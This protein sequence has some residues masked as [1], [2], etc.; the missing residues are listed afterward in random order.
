MNR[1]SPAA[2]QARE[3]AR[4]TD[5]RFG[6][7]EAGESQ[8]ELTGGDR[9][10]TDVEGIGAYIAD[11]AEELAGTTVGDIHSNWKARLN[12]AQQ[13]A[14]EA[15]PAP[16]QPHAEDLTDEHKI[17]IFQRRM[18]HHAGKNP[19]DHGYSYDDAPDQ[20]KAT[21]FLRPASPQWQQANHHLQEVEAGIDQHTKAEL[22]ELTDG[23]LKALAEHHD[24]TG[25]S[26]VT[27]ELA[28]DTG[29]LLRGQLG[30]MI[31]IGKH[32]AETDRRNSILGSL[33][34][35]HR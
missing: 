5:G 30:G 7:Y 15:D 21:E 20:V 23:Y 33:S 25:A 26:V 9:D 13:R 12:A 17:W 28:H 32:P 16:D 6:T 24:N 31:G 22:Q 14:N 4:H 2:E 8:A 3:S 10:P 19:D 11:R 18:L 29:L 1:I 27:G 35:R 34:S